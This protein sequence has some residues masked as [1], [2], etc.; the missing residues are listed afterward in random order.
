MGS[1]KFA[2]PILEKI[3]ENTNLIGVITQPDRPSGR[4][5]PL[6]Q[7][8]VKRLAQ[9]KGLDFIQPQRLQ[10]PDVLQQIQCWNPD[11]IIVTAY[12]KILR[13]NILRLPRFGCINVH[14]SLLPRWRG[15]API[16]A[17]I[18]AGDS[19]TGVTIM[20]MDEGVDTGPILIQQRIAILDDDDSTTLSIRIANAGAQLLIETLPKY[21]DGQISPFPQSQLNQEPTY[22]PMLKKEDGLLDLTQPAVVLS[23]RIRAYHPWP[24]SYIHWQEHILK[25]HKAHTVAAPL[26]TP[27]KRLIFEKFPAIT[28]GDGLLVLDELQPAGKKPMPG[29]VFLQGERKWLSGLP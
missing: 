24:G 29:K 18:L 19:E 5:Q 20:Q 23:R 3:I 26:S 12:G 27:G 17:A 25:I 28:T 2:L 15:A 6:S 13:S 14:A 1:P 10:N 11:V 8:P 7:P 16:Q 9:A 22:A 21:I 4:G